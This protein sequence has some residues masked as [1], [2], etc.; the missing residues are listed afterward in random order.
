VVKENLTKFLLQDNV[1]DFPLIKAQKTSKKQKH[2]KLLQSLIFVLAYT[3][4]ADIHTSL[5]TTRK[6]QT[7]WKTEFLRRLC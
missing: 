4:F 3:F 1:F 5:C 7:F 6:G 2:E